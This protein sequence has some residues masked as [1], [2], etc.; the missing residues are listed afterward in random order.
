MPTPWNEMSFEE[1]LNDLH[2][3]VQ[4]L[5]EMSNEAADRGNREFTTIDRGLSRIEE[6][7]NSLGT[8]VRA[9]LDG[10]RGSAGWSERP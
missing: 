5:V 1:K 10:S 6:A 2:D 7:V 9:L 8:V 3:T 4:R